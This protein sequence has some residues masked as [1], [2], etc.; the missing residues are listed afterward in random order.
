MLF[1]PPQSSLCWAVS[2]RAWCTRGTD[3]S[4]ELHPG[5][6]AFKSPDLTWILC[7]RCTV[8]SQWFKI[9]SFNVCA[10]VEEFTLFIHKDL[11]SRRELCILFC[12]SLRNGLCIPGYPELCRPG[13]PH[14]HRG[15]PTSASLTRRH[16][17]CHRAQLLLPFLF[18]L[19]LA[20]SPSLAVFSFVLTGS[21][22][23]LVSSRVYFQ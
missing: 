15:L 7:L 4:V 21:D 1:P 22:F 3:C 19:S 5:L 11:L 2:P 20:V 16:H 9:N 8:G 6:S 10:L 23:L 18:S 12:F 14:T 17:L 13:W